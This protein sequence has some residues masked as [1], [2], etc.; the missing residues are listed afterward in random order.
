M[1]PTGP[2]LGKR[3]ANSLRIQ[4]DQSDT[5]GYSMRGMH[6]IDHMESFGRM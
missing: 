4:I 6:A 2:V 5:I 3:A 1:G